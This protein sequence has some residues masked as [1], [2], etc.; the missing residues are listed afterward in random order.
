L[1]RRFLWLAAVSVD[2]RR[3]RYSGVNPM[4]L[5]ITLSFEVAGRHGN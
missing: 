2:S 3:E 1:R 5:A 4:A